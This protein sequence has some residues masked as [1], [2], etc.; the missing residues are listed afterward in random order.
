MSETEVIIVDVPKTVKKPAESD[1]VREMDK[2]TEGPDASKHV[3]KVIEIG[4]KQL[5]QG[6]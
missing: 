3:G 1:T 2:A 6:K 5:E 4:K